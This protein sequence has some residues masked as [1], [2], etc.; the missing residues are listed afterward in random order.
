MIERP[1][2]AFSV[3]DAAVL[4]CLVHLARCFSQ[5]MPMESKL[6][7]PSGDSL[8]PY[9]VIES[10]EQLP[11]GQYRVGDSMINVIPTEGER[12]M[13]I[14]EGGARGRRLQDRAAPGLR[15]AR[16]PATVIAAPSGGSHIRVNGNYSSARL[17]SMNH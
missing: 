8:A 3:G 10:T 1:S 6:C 16:Y 14:R 11:S 17:F 12:A 2:S 9:F 13:R 15:K 7:H 4:L 5:L